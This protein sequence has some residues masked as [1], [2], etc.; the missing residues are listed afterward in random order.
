NRKAAAV[1]G[2]AHC[3]PLT[4]HCL[5]FVV[6]DVDVLG[7]DDVVV[8]AGCSTVSSRRRRRSLFATSGFSTGTASAR[9]LAVKGFSQFVRSGLQTIVSV[10]HSIRVISAESTLGFAD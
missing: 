7:I 5:L 1:N 10:V 4:A 6:F 8:T 2:P 9:G 3:L